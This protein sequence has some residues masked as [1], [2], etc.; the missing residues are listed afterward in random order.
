MSIEPDILVN[1]VFELWDSGIKDDVTII[2]QLQS[3]FHISENN[4]ESVFELTQTGCLRAY[5]KAAGQSYPKNNLEDNA[6]VK[7]A[8]RICL[9]KLGKPELNKD[10]DKK[11]PWWK[12]WQ[13]G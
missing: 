1:R 8:L 11:K 7:S 13:L 9:V 5:F 2:T 10:P 4:A 3:E 12:L 6:I